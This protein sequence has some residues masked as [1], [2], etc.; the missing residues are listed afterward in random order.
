MLAGRVGERLGIA[1]GVSCNFCTQQELDGEGT[2]GLAF[3]VESVVCD[4]AKLPWC[5]EPSDRRNL[6]DESKFF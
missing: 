1:G 6:T 4:T 3:P 2:L 5:S